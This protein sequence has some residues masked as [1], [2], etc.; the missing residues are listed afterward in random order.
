MSGPVP[1]VPAGAGRPDRELRAEVTV[2]A[3]PATVWDA[4]TDV[5][6]MP[7]WSPELVRMVP[8]RRGGLR[9]GQW[10]L[11]L[12]RR[13]PVVWPTRNVVSVLDA[14][15]TVGWDTT[16]SGARWIY[17]VEQAA[18]ADGE[19]RTRVTLRRPVP[20]RLTLASR[21]VAATL[22]GGAAEHADELEDGMRRTLEG[23]KADVE[24]AS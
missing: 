20:G 21:V 3:S 15:R 17:S 14:G 24:R 9:L 13:G 4:L 23:L 18:A 2:R 5:D 12:N 19:E 11:G 16:S 7:G 6:R 8:L 22:L 10:Y 1:G